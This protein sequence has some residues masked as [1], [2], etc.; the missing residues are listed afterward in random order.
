MTSGAAVYDYLCRDTSPVAK[1][2]VALI[3]ALRMERGLR[4]T[5]YL[6]SVWR[7]ILLAFAVTA[8]AAAIAAIEPGMGT[9]PLPFHNEP[10]PP[11]K[12][13][14]APGGFRPLHLILTMPMS[15]ERNSGSAP[16]WPLSVLLV[17]AAA[18]LAVTLRTVWLWARVHTI[19]VKIANGRLNQTS[20]V[21]SRQIET[22]DL[23][24]VR[25][26][27]L[28]RTLLMRLTGDGRLVFHLG[29]SKERRV[30]IAGLAKGAEL[31]RIYQQLQDLRFALRANPALK[32]IV[33][34]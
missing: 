18:W 28:E 23:W 31:D 15:T 5:A 6:S 32:G 25:D 33:V 29:S 7:G 24:L 17:A 26:L 12:V 34:Q 1:Q 22:I 20:G 11:L 3:D 13:Q 14:P 10:S 21:L 30:A 8:A 19:R 2:A 4:F 27:V 16:A 9:I